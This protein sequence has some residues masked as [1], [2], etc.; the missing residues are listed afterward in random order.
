MDLALS[1]PGTFLKISF[2]S[3]YTIESYM[4][5]R[6][7]CV[8]RAAETRNVNRSLVGKRLGKRP[9]GHRIDESTMFGWIRERITLDLCTKN[10]LP[11]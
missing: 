11:N 6:I 5:S 8:V 7:Q 9:L 3:P 4:Y 10:N 1:I 2:C